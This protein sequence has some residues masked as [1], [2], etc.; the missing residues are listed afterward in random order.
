MNDFYKFLKFQAGVKY[1]PILLV[2]KVLANDFCKNVLFN[3]EKSF[4][5]INAQGISH[6]WN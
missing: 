3:D 2:L 6:V 4:N 5:E 1:I